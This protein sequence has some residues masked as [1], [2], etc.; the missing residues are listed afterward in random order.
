MSQTLIKVNSSQFNYIYNGRVHFPYSIAT[1]VA[2]VK[3]NENLNPRFNFEKT[4][5][6]HKF[7]EDLIKQMKIYFNDKSNDNSLHQHYLAI[8]FIRWTKTQ[9]G[10]VCDFL[11]SKESKEN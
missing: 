7:N 9:Q 4:F 3:N 1:I 11:L 10:A 2:Q 5:V 8:N 6:Q